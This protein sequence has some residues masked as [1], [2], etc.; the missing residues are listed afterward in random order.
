MVIV[1]SLCDV[2]QYHLYLFCVCHS[3]TKTK[4]N[5]KRKRNLF[6]GIFVKKGKKERRRNIFKM[7]TLYDHW[8]LRA[9][10]RA[11]DVGNAKRIFFDR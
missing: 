4:E 2:V 9:R 3:E 6:L 8:L 11:V 5:K 10:R 1:D 7:E